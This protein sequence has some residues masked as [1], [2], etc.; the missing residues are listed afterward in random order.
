L[1]KLSLVINLFIFLQNAKEKSNY[2]T[3]QKKVK[4]MNGTNHHIGGEP[5][6]SQVQPNAHQ[7]HY[8]TPHFANSSQVPPHI[9]AV[10]GQTPP[11]GGLHTM[12][13]LQPN[14]HQMLYA[15]PNFANSSQVPAPTFVIDGQTPPILQQPPHVCILQY[16]NSNDISAIILIVWQYYQIMKMSSF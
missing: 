4:E 16:G 3:K 11:I 6:M 1:P 7:M 12:S 8:P 10:N 5:M 13:Q 9:Y 15:T 2:N 14:A